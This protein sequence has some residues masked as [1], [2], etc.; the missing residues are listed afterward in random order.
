M[1]KLILSILFFMGIHLLHAQGPVIR[2]EKDTF[3]FGSIEQGELVTYQFKF[4]NTGNEPLIVTEVH[5]SCSCLVGSCSS[6]PIPPHKSG[7]V[8]ITFN[9]V[10][11]IG[12]Q[13]KTVTISSNAS[14]SAVKI[15]WV[16]GNVTI[17]KTG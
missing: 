6:E 14:N 1:R 7:V 11:K 10:G 3:N 5:T 12:S 17:K 8:M 4:T 9:S 2:F 13:N 15:L 16:Q